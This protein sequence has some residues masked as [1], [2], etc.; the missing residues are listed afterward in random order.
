[1]PTISEENARLLALARS[2][3]DDP[4]AAIHLCEK[5]LAHSKEEL[6]DTTYCEALYL[7]G[8]NKRIL[9][10]LNQAEADLLAAHCVATT[11]EDNTLLAG[12]S[13]QLGVLYIDQ[14]Q[15]EQA[16]AMIGLAAAMYGKRG[17]VEWEAKALFTLGNAYW[18]D[19]REHEAIDL[20]HQALS[21]FASI[22]FDEGSMAVYCGLAHIDMDRERYE[23]A[24]KRLEVCSRLFQTSAHT[25]NQLFLELTLAKCY[26]KLGRIERAITG[27]RTTIE[28]ANKLGYPL[29]ECHGLLLLAHYLTREG[30]TAEPAILRYRA[31]QLAVTHG[32]VEGHDALAQEIGRL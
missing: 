26:Y 17:E 4:Q 15:L 3:S 24:R 9:G 13:M 14:R 30:D 23:D 2:S 22:G 10:K 1:M 11:L 32:F 27:A 20:L 6:G 21:K 7:S 18:L 28:R 19:R 16:G 25:K 29:L 31:K 5:V 12:T 8:F